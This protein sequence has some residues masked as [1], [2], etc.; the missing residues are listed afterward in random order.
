VLQQQHILPHQG[1]IRFPRGTLP[2]PGCR[3]PKFSGRDVR[4][5]RGRREFRARQHSSREVLASPVRAVQSRAAGF[6]DRVQMADIGPSLEIGMHAPARKMR[7]GT[8]GTH[9]FVI[10]TP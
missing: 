7:R 3:Q 10:S 8:T 1:R 2:G 5:I 4:R 6:A 9:S